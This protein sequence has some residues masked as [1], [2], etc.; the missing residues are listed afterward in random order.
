MIVERSRDYSLSQPLLFLALQALSLNP[1]A[2]LMEG[3]F[4]FRI[5]EG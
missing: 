2:S 3:S 4:V 1:A 5:I